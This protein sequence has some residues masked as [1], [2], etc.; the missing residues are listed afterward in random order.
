MTVK[1]K[2]NQCT[3]CKEFNGKHKQYCPLAP[4]K[5]RKGEEG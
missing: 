4:Y 2:D 3:M 1:N 5:D